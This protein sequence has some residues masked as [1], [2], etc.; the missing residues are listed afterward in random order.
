MSRRI[1]LGVVTLVLVMFTSCEN[2]PLEGTFFTDT[3]QN[4]F[5]ATIDG[6]EY[7]EDV[8]VAVSNG[9]SIVITASTSDGQRAITLGFP[10]SHVPGDYSITDTG[11]TQAT[12]MPSGPTSVE[13][14]TAGTLTIQEHNTTTRYIKGIF[15]FTT[16]SH[17]ITAGTFM[18]NY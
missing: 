3:S 17:S 12:Y 7:V 2:E 4:G 1:L 6:S 5:T 13:I 8:I 15:N 14:A 18:V 16:P 10:E 11:D 9:I